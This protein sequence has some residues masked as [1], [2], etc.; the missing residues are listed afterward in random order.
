MRRGGIAH[1]AAAYEYFTK[2]A[3]D[4]IMLAGGIAVIAHPVQ[5]F[6]EMKEMDSLLRKE[7]RA[8]DSAELRREKRAVQ[9]LCAQGRVD[10]NLWLGS[11]RACEQAAS[12]KTVSGYENE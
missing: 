12:G 3:I 6:K 7:L 1:K 5:R 2:E 10:A 4:E 9:S 11:S 8:G